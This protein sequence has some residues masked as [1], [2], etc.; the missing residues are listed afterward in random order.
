MWSACAGYKRGGI[1]L[2]ARGLAEWPVFRL[3]LF[4]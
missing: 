4:A 3:V 2:P 1:L